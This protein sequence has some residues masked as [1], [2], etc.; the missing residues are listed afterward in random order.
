MKTGRES[1]TIKKM[2]RKESMT[3]MAKKYAAHAG[4]WSRFPFLGRLLILDQT[5]VEKMLPRRPII[6]IVTPM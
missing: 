2:R 5:I 6:A 3:A 1:P 4:V